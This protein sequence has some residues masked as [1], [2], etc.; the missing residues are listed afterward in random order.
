MIKPVG[1][2]GGQR[3]YTN[4]P[5]LDKNKMTSTCKESTAHVELIRIGLSSVCCQEL[6][7]ICVC[8]FCCSGVVLRQG[9]H[10]RAICRLRW[11]LLCARYGG[12]HPLPNIPLSLH[13]PPPQG[14]AAPFRGQEGLTSERRTEEGSGTFHH[15]YCKLRIDCSQHMSTAWLDYAAVLYSI[16]YPHPGK[17]QKQSALLKL[18]YWNEIRYLPRAL[19]ALIL[20]VPVSQRTG[21]ECIRIRGC[22][23]DDSKNLYQKLRQNLCL[24]SRLLFKNALFKLLHIIAKL[25]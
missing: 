12:V 22:E 5:D 17:L 4:T 8:M 13:P 11:C 15:L 25:A 6:C 14:A 10:S 7:C 9:M 3:K 18:K 23:I 19:T 21:K 2:K 20:S 24:L 1:G 16:F